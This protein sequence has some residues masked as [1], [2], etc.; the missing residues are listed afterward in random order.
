M[1]QHNLG[2]F[3]EAFLTILLALT[4]TS[5]FA[6]PVEVHLKQQATNNLV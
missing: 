3:K 5:S 6:E 1:K 4:V 2:T